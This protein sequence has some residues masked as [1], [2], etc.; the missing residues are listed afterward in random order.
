MLALSSCVTREVHQGHEISSNAV[1]KLKTNKT[2]KG[3]AVEILGEPS[4]SST[5]DD[6][7]WYYVSIKRTGVSAFSQGTAYYN[8]LQLNF[9][10]NVLRSIKTYSGSKEK[11]IFD[12]NKTPVYGD[13]MSVFTDFMNNMGRFG[14][15]QSKS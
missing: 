8:I 7:T 12:D 5:F 4:F 13:N 1:A 11:G 14:Q 3:G 6:D 2:T 9:K 10:A 15:K